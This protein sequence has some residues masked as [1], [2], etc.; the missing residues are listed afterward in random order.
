MRPI[1]RPPTPAAS[2]SGPRLWLVL[3]VV[4]AAMWVS[5]GR[6]CHALKPPLPAPQPPA[7][8]DLRKAF[9][10]NDNR[11]EAAQHARTFAAICGSVADYLEYDGTRPEPLI[12]TGV[13]VDEFRRAC[14]RPARGAGH[15][16]PNIPSSGRRSKIISRSSW[17][18]A[19]GRSTKRSA[20]SGSPRCGRCSS[21]PPTRPTGGDDDYFFS[22]HGCIRRG[23]R[24]RCVVWRS[25][26]R[27]RKNDAIRGA[28][29]LPKALC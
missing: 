3:V 9:S 27:A 18:P 28:R 6:G 16:W 8:P 24:H 5:S 11:S 2:S 19:A 21:V 12:K 26:R 22:L 29:A 13:H 7:G 17:A 10:A 23:D 1:F 20:T 14:G 4:A 15:S 25:R